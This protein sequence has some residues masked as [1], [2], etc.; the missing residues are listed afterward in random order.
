VAEAD[1]REGF[2]INNNPRV[3]IIIKNMDANK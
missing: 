3:R 2:K 1:L